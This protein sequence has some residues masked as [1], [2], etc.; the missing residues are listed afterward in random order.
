MAIDEASERGGGDGSTTGA[1]VESHTHA[2]WPRWS[3]VWAE[4]AALSPQASFFVGP[5]WVETWLEVFGAQLRPRILVVRGGGGEVT[6]ICLV[7]FRTERRGPFPVRRVYLN[8][9]GEDEADDTCLEY[10]G[11]LCRP[12]HE[13]AV[14]TALGAWLAGET[15]D[16]LVCNAMTTAIAPQPLEGCIVTQSEG[17]SHHVDLTAFAPTLDGFLGAISR[18]SREQIRRSLRLY[19]EKSG[20]IAVRA[21][22][23]VA[24]AHA[25]LAELAALHQASWQARGQPGVFSSPRFV[26]FHRALI[27]R[28][29]PAGGCQLLRI[30]AG[31]DTIGVLY[32]FVHAGKV[33]FYQSGLQPTGQ[34]NR[35]KPGLV[36]HA[37][38]IA[39]A[40][41]AGLREYDFLVGDSQ[42]KK[43]LSTGSR[44]LTWQI[45][46]RRGIKLAAI[47]LLRRVRDGINRSR[48]VAE[49]S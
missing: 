31:S 4:L 27:A 45:F 20:E 3:G 6:G 49:D 15:W 47:S 21:A 29:L 2:S 44:R 32:D 14:V 46:Q 19:R 5:S 35:L 24:E 48:R 39:H 30:A 42:Y 25:L 7:V 17:T 16:E 26:A 11:L 43:S 13:A 40:A 22:T 10:N 41:A 8:T 34:D 33:Y 23:T 18:N 1:R 28:T 9:A 36:A 37:S 38:A 12:G